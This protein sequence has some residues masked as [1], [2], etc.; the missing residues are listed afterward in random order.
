MTTNQLMTYGAV[1]FA[2]FAIY[3]ITRTPGKTLASQ[4]GQQQRD[5]TLTRFH[6]LLTGQAALFNGNVGGYK[7]SWA[8][9]FEAAG[10]FGS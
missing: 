2:A 7:W 4:P 3:Y 5:A 6:D 8:P 10:T 1:G 9:D